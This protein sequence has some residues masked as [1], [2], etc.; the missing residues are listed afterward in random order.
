MAFTFAVDATSGV[1]VNSSTG[2]VDFTNAHDDFAPDLGH[3]F[4][5]YDLNLS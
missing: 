4:Y 3:G 2:D 1:V 5:T